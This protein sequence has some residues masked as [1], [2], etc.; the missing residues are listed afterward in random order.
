MN[1]EIRN[2]RKSYGAREVLHSVN[3]TIPS[4]EITA[5]LGPSGSGKSTLLRLIAGLE[6]SDSGAIFFDG[7]DVTHVPVS[8]RNIGFCFQDYAPFRHMS[9]FDNVAYGL[10][11]RK[12]S[13][14][15]IAVEATELLV[16]MGLA[17][18]A[19]QLPHQ[20]SGGQRQRMA[21]A[22]A[23]AIRPSVLLLDEPFAALDAKIRSEVRQFVR[24]LQ[25]ELGITTILV[26]HD[27][28]E[29][30]EVAD[31]LAVLHDGTVQQ[32]GTPAMVYD[33][34]ENEFVQSFIGPT[35][36]F[37][38]STVRPHQLRVRRSGAG[39]AGTV[40]DIVQLGFEV[41][42]FITFHNGSE[43]WVQVS[44]YDNEITGLQTGDAV[45]LSLRTQVIPGGETAELSGTA[46]TS[47]VAHDA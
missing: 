18:H 15:Q 24:D 45:V 37:R 12:L 36:E 25:R 26:T 9:V 3:L 27:Q 4:G 5:L 44:R 21:L 13:E 19:Q 39:E 33:R 16:R 40:T 38:G 46:A 11:V 10:R 17:S 2:L 31:S 1:I 28:T 6:G 42:L 32:A 22:R 41:R 47:H 14:K 8:D 34:P 29:A 23:L 20:L 35:T 30:M 43:S 7:H